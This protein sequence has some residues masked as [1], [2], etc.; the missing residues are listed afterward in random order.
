MP[1]PTVNVAGTGAAA[2]NP[3]I[4]PEL[5]NVF[6]SI[7]ALGGDGEESKS[8]P[9]IS[10]T[11][12]LTKS[13]QKLSKLAS[14]KTGLQSVQLTDEDTE[15][16]ADALDPLMDDLAKYIDVLPYLPLVIFAIGY[17]AGIIAEVLDRRKN[18][19]TQDRKIERVQHAVERESPITQP[20]V[21]PQ[22]QTNSNQ[23]NTEVNV[24]ASNMND[25]T[26]SEATV[27]YS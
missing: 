3:P 26:N 18:P 22:P 21:Q 27:T 7:D 4:N 2:A 1:T 12:G 8:K 13:L 17:A 10:I 15:E 5:E 11:G 16:L 19:Q 6:S 20:F 23:S 25:K 9:K 14:R 24:T